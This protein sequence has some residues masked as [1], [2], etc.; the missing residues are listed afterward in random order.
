MEKR[1]K[2]K[3]HINLRVPAETL[4]FFKQFPNYTTKMREVLVEFAQKG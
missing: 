2:P 1:K 3:V 4:E